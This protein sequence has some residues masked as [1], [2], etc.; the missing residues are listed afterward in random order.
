MPRI[1]NF[2]ESKIIDMEILVRPKSSQALLVVNSDKWHGLGTMTKN[3][4][5]W[6][7]QNNIIIGA[8]T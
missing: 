2:R 4:W 7:K 6:D 3:Q 5:N 8:A 1:G